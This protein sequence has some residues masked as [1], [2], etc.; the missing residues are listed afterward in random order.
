[1]ECA[2]VR[3]PAVEVARRFRKAGKHVSRDGVRAA[4]EID[5]GRHRCEARG[6]N[7]DRILDLFVDLG[8]VRE[9]SGRS[10]GM[11]AGIPS[12]MSHVEARGMQTTPPTAS[13]RLR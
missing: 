11:Q 10:P 12:L 6:A 13:P 1:M 2:P 9:R 3:W 8:H 4:I 7:P 5:L